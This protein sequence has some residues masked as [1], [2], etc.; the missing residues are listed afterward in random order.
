MPVLAQTEL[1]T[2][3]LDT[4]AQ[5]I[6]GGLVGVL[7]VLAIVL[8]VVVFFGGRIVMQ[9]LAFISRVTTAIE[10]MDK[11][12]DKVS[13]QT[14]SQ[15]TILAELAVTMSASKTSMDNVADEVRTN[16][17]AT[18]DIYKE[19]AQSASILNR[20]LVRAEVFFKQRVDEIEKLLNRHHT[21]VMD[22]VAKIQPAPAATPEL[23]PPPTTTLP[24]G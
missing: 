1:A 7:I 3:A 14:E 5:A 23:P 2:K 22:A 24:E 13:D 4:V 9:M 19:S 18:V 6:Q 16:T 8:G 21:E 17:K 11:A 15:K 10:S 12:L 20:G